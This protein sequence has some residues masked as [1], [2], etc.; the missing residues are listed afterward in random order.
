MN[1]IEDI[2]YPSPVM[3]TVLA[4]CREAAGTDSLVLLLGESGSGKDYLARY[5]H[6]HS[7]RAVGPYLSINCAAVPEELAESELFGHEHGAFTGTQ[8]RKRGLLELAEN[9]TLLLNEIGDLSLRLQ[10]KLLTF[11]DTRKFTRVGGEK[12]VSVNARI[13]V[14]TNRDLEKEAA[15]GRFRQDLFYRLNVLSIE[16]P[17][18]REN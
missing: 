5:I 14:A 3:Q 1:E 8:G 4:A 12:E 18:L 7:K 6:N 10:A 17:P 2:D 11:L 16:V 13:I 9:G 15:T